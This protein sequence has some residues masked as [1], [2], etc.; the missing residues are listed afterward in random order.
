LRDGL[1]V[2]VPARDRGIDL[3]AYSH[4]SS[5]VKEFVARPI[6]MK[7]SSEESFSIDRKYKRVANL[8]I[9]YVWH[10][11]D[12]NATVT[13]ALTYEEA[14]AVARKGWGRA[15]GNSASCKRSRYST[16]KPSQ[17]LHTLLEPFK[18]AEGKWR[19]KVTG[20]PYRRRFG[21]RA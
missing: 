18:T 9:A 7:A 14:S 17:Q 19:E 1:D 12:P 15:K 6:Q 10:V 13:Y 8:I 2:A 11:H 16:N 3:I 5:N 20:T 4:L 21:L